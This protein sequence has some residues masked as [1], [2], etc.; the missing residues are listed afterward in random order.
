MNFFKY[1][2]REECLEAS[3]ALTDGLASGAASISYPAGGSLSYTSFDNASNLLKMLHARID[4][5]DGKRPSRAISYT[6]I[7]VKRGR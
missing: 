7:V 6:P 3:R 2:T 5:L 4:Q 1:W